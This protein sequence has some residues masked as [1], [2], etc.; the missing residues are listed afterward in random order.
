MKIL[1]GLTLLTL[2]MTSLSA[3]TG[4]GLNNQSSQ[5]SSISISYIASAT[6]DSNLTISQ[7]SQPVVSGGAVKFTVSGVVGYTSGSTV[8][9]T[10]P[11]GTWSGTDYTTGN[12]TS[13]CTVSF[14]SVPTPPDIGSDMTFSGVSNSGLTV[15]WGTA[16]DVIDAT[17]QLKYK[18]VKASSTSSVDTVDKFDAITTS[19]AGLVQDWTTNSTSVTLNGLSAGDFHYYVVGIKNAR[20][21]IAMYYPLGRVTG[22][23]LY[24]S[25][26]WIP[27]NFGALSNADN[28]CSSH[29]N[30]VTDTTATIKAMIT[31]GATR[32]ACATPY[33]GGGASENVDWP[34][35]ANVTYYTSEGLVLGTT[36]AAGIFTSDFSNPVTPGY[37]VFTLLGLK[38]DWTSYSPAELCS[39][40]TSADQSGSYLGNATQTGIAS[41]LFYSVSNCENLTTGVLQ[42]KL[43]CVEQ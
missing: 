18:V 4:G 3:C 33:C 42:Q 37:I 32:V 28:F 22:K 36:S 27:G 7:L 8:G 19:G 12:I 40:Y 43:V 38:T 6:G 23:I 9:G 34:L 25:T 1:S 26:S 14:S 41:F 21:G 2:G 17:N 5:A 24:L 15:N 16:S 35:A 11:A 20:G 39:S 13:N 31:D 29:K 30:L 10:C